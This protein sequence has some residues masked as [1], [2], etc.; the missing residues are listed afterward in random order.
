MKLDPAAGAEQLDPEVD[1]PSELP[2]GPLACAQTKPTKRATTI[3]THKPLRVQNC[4]M[5][6]S[7]SDPSGTL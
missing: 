6:T 5:M 2:T 7:M 3:A 4:L 1:P